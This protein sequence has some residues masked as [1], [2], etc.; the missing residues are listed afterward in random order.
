MNSEFKVGLVHRL[1]LGQSAWK[2]TVAIA[3]LLWVGATLAIDLAA[4]PAL[5]LGGMMQQADFAPTGWLL[6][7]SF[8]H[9]GLLAS[10]VVLTGSIA[11]GYRHEISR[12]SERWVVAIA[13][14]L[15]AIVLMQTYWLAPTMAGL[16]ASLSWAS[17]AVAPPASMMLWHGSYFGLETLKLVLSVSLLGLC[18][19]SS[20]MSDS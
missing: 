12:L 9:V 14:V 10:A 2:M 19:R 5:Y 13:A 8:N 1:S 16:G 17:P 18:A 7:N 11:L 3:L 6:L 20:M 4:M 15:M